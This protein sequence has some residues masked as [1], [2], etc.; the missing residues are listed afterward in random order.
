MNFEWDESKNEAN[1]KKHGVSFEEAK[2]IF[3]NPIFTNIDERKNY[4]ETREIS[5]GMIEY[6]TAIIVVHTTRGNKTRIISARKA[7][8][9]ERKVY[10]DYIKKT[11][12]RN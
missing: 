11:T 12:Q 3:N 1:K 10:F 6:T 7:N 4:G 9:K 8:L 2:H 5:I